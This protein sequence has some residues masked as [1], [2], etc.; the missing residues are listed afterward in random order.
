MPNKID[1]Q[2]QLIYIRH[3]PKPIYQDQ[4][5]I[6]I[7]IYIYITSMIIYETECENWDFE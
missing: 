3:N 1:T 6:Y 7:Y 5:Y 2:I 4:L